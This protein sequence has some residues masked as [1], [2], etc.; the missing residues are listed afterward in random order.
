MD[1]LLIDTYYISTTLVFYCVHI[2]LYKE[3]CITIVYKYIS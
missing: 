2:K 1:P 3:N